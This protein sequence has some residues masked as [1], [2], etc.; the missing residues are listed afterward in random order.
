MELTNKAEQV[1]K[2]PIENR[3]KSFT[4]ARIIGILGAR[5][6][7]NAQYSNRWRARKTEH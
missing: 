7:S 1:E 2:I 3:E 5:E 6:F 4:F